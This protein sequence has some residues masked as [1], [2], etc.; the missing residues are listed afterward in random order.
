ME[1][2]FEEQF[3]V[4]LDLLGFDDA[5]RKTDADSVKGN[6]ETPRILGLLSQISELRCESD[7]HSEGPEGNSTVFIKPT[8]S[9]YSDSIVISYPLRPTVD[10]L[11]VGEEMTIAGE[12][13][14]QA[15]F[16]VARTAAMALR[17][18]FL[19]RGGATIGNLY[20]AGGIMFGKAF[21]DA[22][23]IESH[24]SIYP[25]VVLAQEILRRIDRK[26]W[27]GD[28]ARKGDDGLYY[29]DYFRILA[30]NDVIPGDSV[31]AG[32]EAWIQ[33]VQGIVDRE[34]KRLRGEENIR[35]LAKWDWFESEFQDGMER[36]ESYVPKCNGGTVALPGDP[37]LDSLM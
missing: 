6:I 21:L 28:T 16:L 29:F 17:F 1:P 37:G 5:V 10:A 23:E 11:G 3:I 4:F 15:R 24:T 2:K 26:D 7:L 13:M 33:Y 19:V 18:G 8:I 12:L 25:R 32:R 30:R 34:R 9:A 14:W 27:L 22:Y 31:D 35:A 36:S 20:H